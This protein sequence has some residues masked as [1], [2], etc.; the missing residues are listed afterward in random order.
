MAVDYLVRPVTESEEELRAQLLHPEYFAEKIEKLKSGSSRMIEV[1]AVRSALRDLFQGVEQQV[2]YTA[3]GKPY[4]VPDQAPFISIS[5]TKGYVAV[6]RSESPVGID[7]E[8]RGNRVERVVSH[9]LKPEELSHLSEVGEE[10]KRQLSLHLAWSAKEAAF[11][12]L[13]REFY[14]L[15][16][17]TSVT[18]VDWETK[19]LNLSVVGQEQPLLVHFEYTDDYVLVY[20]QRKSL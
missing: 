4:L 3:E 15:Q 9:F 12:I 14:D 16:H 2:F 7:I 5:H 13:G 17:L 6:I 18:A 1:L 20:C 19:T 10:E 11:K 8:R